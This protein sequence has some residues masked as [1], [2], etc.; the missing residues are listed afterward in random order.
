[1][2]EV[3][4]CWFWR[5]KVLYTKDVRVAF[6]SWERPLANSYQENGHLNPI[7]LGNQILPKT[8]MRLER[9]PG[10]QVRT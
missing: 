7:I 8:Y 6:Q 3:L 2:R 5:W 10:L 4:H 1:M 9:A